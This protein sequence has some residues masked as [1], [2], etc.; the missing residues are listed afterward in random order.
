M[1]KDYKYERFYG[2]YFSLGGDVPWAMLVEM[3]ADNLVYGIIFG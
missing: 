2:V 3:E 1:K